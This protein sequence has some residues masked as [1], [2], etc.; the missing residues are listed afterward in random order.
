MSA[1]NQNNIEEI[2]YKELSSEIQ[3]ELLKLKNL[4]R[5]QCSFC[6]T[7]QRNI[8]FSYEINSVFYYVCSS[9]IVKLALNDIYEYYQQTDDR[10]KLLIKKE[11]ESISIYLTQLMDGN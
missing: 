8:L 9:C 11:F 2:K 10:S 5:K 7:V 1:M 3:N 4:I 6:S